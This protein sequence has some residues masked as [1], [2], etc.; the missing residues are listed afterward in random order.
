MPAMAVDCAVP[1]GVTTFISEF[2]VKLTSAVKMLSVEG[3]T[4]TP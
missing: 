2:E 4:P 3:L 1:F